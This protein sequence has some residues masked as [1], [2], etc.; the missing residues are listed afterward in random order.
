MFNRQK[1]L[2]ICLILVTLFASGAKAETVFI[3]PGEVGGQAINFQFTNDN[4]AFVDLLWS[5]NKT[6]EWEA[7]T[8]VFLLYGRLCLGYAGILLD[9]VGNEIPDT[10]LAGRTPCTSG[11]ELSVGVIDLPETTVF[12]GI[13]LVSGFQDGD[14]WQWNWDSADR[15]VVGEV[16]SGNQAPVDITSSIFL[17]LL[18]DE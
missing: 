10:E 2:V 13:R 8:H 18:G 3:N 9:A 11:S 16:A 5:D 12:S 14:A 4:A 6:L 15:P 17:L 7:G 1:T